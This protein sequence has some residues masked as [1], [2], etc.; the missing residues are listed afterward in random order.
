VVAPAFFV[1]GRVA[2]APQR[3]CWRSGQWP[4]T[5]F[6]LLD[7]DSAEEVMRQAW[8][9][10]SATSLDTTGKFTQDDWRQLA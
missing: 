8:Q 3:R 9:I 4:S 7:H 5:Y 6:R 1:V 10:A 2:S